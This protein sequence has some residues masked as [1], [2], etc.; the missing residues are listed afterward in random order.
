MTAIAPD[1]EESER[2]LAG[3]SLALLGNLAFASSDAIIKLL[4]THHY[5]VFQLA[6]MQAS[7]AAIPLLVLLMKDGGPARLR[8]RNPRLVVLR[9]LLAGFGGTCA[10]FAFS[11]LP[12]ADSYAIAF[13]TPLIVTILSIPILGE[14]VGIHR[15]GAVVVGLIGVLVM[16]RPGFA[17]VGPGHGAMFLAAVNGA[18]VVLIMR[19][20]ARY[21]QRAVMVTAAIGG[22]LLVNLPGMALTFETPALPDLGLAALGGLLMGSG[23]F[24]I[25][26]GL[27]LAP[28]SAVAPMQ[29]SMML[30]AVIY[31]VLIF[32]TPV[33]PILLAG[34]VIVIASGLYI[35]H[36]ERRRGRTLRAHVESV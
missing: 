20:I 13:S 9:G 1:F 24:L 4:S 30:W 28:A 21:E 34:A 27:S 36:R 3:I 18:V 33:D 35:M 15:W 7:F 26:R 29:Y 17:A 8:V 11:Q 16:V 25:V 5:S 31:G 32:A 22:Q 23:Q 14:K 12:L 19:K 2:V 10:V 6:F